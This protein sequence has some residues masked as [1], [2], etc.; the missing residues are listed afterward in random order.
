MRGEEKP[1][2]KNWI[3]CTKRN[4]PVFFINS[5]GIFKVLHFGFGYGSRELVFLNRPI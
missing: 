5:L 1:G 2:I 3:F 4:G